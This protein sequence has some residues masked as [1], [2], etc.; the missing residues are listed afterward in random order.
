MPY[1]AAAGQEVEAGFLPC[2]G[3]SGRAAE[4][5][6]LPY[7]A[8]RKDRPALAALSAAALGRRQGFDWGG[9]VGQR[10][11]LCLGCEP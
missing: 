1:E 11:Y 6:S 9:I 8:G 2:G 4:I 5:E 3:L 7:E 10:F